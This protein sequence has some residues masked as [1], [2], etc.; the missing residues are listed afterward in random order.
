MLGEQLG[1]HWLTY[2]PIHFRSFH[3]AALLNAPTAAR[4]MVEHFPAARTYLD[5][6]AGTGVFSAE[7]NRL[8]VSATACEHSTAGR[9]LAIR[10]G[11]D[12]RP[13][14]LA[15]PPYASVADKYDVAFCFEVAEHLPQL[16]GG[17]LVTFLSTHSDTVVF[18]A[19]QPGQ[20]GTGH[21]N[22]QPKSYWI[23]AFQNEGMGVAEQATLAISDEFR[24]AQIPGRYLAD[25][26][27]VFHRQRP[28]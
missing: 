25:N 2:N 20:G 14:D 26:L 3:E 27:L 8:G 4:V 12:C 22:E 1:W 15:V 6:G 7:L 28:C 18:T 21:I 9:R 5:V 16:L 10:Q 19:A 17:N 23:Q 24:I 13:L 11:V